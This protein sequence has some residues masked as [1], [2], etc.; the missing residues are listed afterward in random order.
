M[1]QAEATY[2]FH[3]QA[4]ERKYEDA[5][6][7]RLELARVSSQKIAE[8][9]TAVEQWQK[10]AQQWGQVAKMTQARAEEAAVRSRQVSEGG[11][12]SSFGNL[13]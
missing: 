3:R 9:E 12:G 2:I 10:H 4:V 6:K 13:M 5:V 8:L 1:Q 11:A 7:Q